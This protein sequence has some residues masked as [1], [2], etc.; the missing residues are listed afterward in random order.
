MT[1]D[2]A[3]CTLLAAPDV[4]EPLAAWFAAGS[5]STSV[6]PVKT[7]R[8]RETVAGEIAPGLAVHVKFHRAVTL[9]D[10]ARDAWRGARGLVE[11]D[12][13]REASR[14]SLPCVEGLAAGRIETADGSRSFVVTRS[15]P[16]ANPLPRGPLSA[17]QA[18]AAGCLL[19]SAHDAGLHARDLHPANVLCRPDGSLLLCDLTSATWAEPLDARDRARGLAF[20][21]QDLDGGV[22][23]PAAV[24]LIRAYSPTPLTLACA[25]LLARRLRAR[26]LVAFGRRATRACRH[27]DAV[28][29][30]G[31][32]R[33]FLAREAESLHDAARAAA[34][35]P[36]REAKKSGRRGAV[37][38]AGPLV[39]KQRATA[40]A[41]RLF[42]ASYR[43]RFAGVP[44]AAP[45]ALRLRH[46][47]GLVFTARV[48]G[49]DLRDELRAHALSTRALCDAARALGKSVGRLH[50]HGL[51]NRDLKLENLVRD[52]A[53]GAVLMVDLDGVRAKSA[54]DGRG[55][56]HDLGRLLAAV[57]E[58]RLAD[59][60][61]VVRTFW[62]SYLAARR[63]LRSTPANDL[64]RRTAVRA[65]AW[66][67]SH[68]VTIAP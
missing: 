43:L 14:R 24:P 3:R 27:T 38:F 30:A 8:V 29:E 1:S 7:S 9:A 40:P 62:R 51:R 20:F 4:I 59:H 48:P 26:A 16:G 36:P 15:V 5:P 66:A 45:V 21:C 35:S 44:A 63:C 60:A 19:R 17:E 6:R 42:Q 28:C 57:D 10:R 65:R 31:D 55:Q 18:T 46:G 12:R 39:V 11:L 61:L 54:C 50:S 37:W 34:A 64:R 13:L 47:I 25:T 22:D 23:D 56:A 32:V 58:C 52:P 33:W 68:T 49:P 53:T 2:G 67:R 41:Q